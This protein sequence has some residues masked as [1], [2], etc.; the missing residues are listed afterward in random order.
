MIFYCIVPR[1]F[2]FVTYTMFIS[3]IDIWW[4]PEIISMIMD[5]YQAIMEIKL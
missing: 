3:T 5:D 1:D 4:Y 2:F